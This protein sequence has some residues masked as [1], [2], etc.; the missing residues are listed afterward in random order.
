MY[1]YVNIHIYIHIQVHMYIYICIHVYQYLPLRVFECFLFYIFP[2][3]NDLHSTFSPHHSDLS[4]GKGIIKIS[5]KMLPNLEWRERFNICLLMNICA[6][7]QFII[8]HMA[9]PYLCI[10][11]TYINTH[12]YAFLP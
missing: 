4:R 8:S 10:I 1:L 7:I 5:L 2:L 12:L 11:Y 6:I 3:K 9:W